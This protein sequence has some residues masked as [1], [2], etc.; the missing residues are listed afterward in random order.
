VLAPDFRGRGLSEYDPRSERYAPPTYALDVV[1]LLQHAGAERAIFF[2]TSLGGL[3]TMAIASFAPQLI[4]GALLN[5]VGPEL[6]TT[7]IDRIRTYVGKQ[8]TFGNWEEAA[9]DMQRKHGNVHPRYG[10]AEWLRYARRVFRKDADGVRFDYDMAI[11]DNFNGG[12]TGVVVDSWPFYRALAGR[13]VLVLRGENSD[14]LEPAILE[15]MAREVPDAEVVTVRGVG[16]A[17]DLD[18][19]DSVAAIDRLLARVLA[20][21]QR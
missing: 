11:A 2:G 5:D 18:E 10:E 15:R 3:V 17:P 7:G 20:A 1:E 21:D 13:P 14:L 8:R 9:A 16:H 12:D 6:D 19:P 4:A